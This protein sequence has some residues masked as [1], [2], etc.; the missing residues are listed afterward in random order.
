MENFK[1]ILSSND[2]SPNLKLTIKNTS[3]NCYKVLKNHLVLDGE[4]EQDNF[5]V[6]DN[7]TR[8]HLPYQG[9]TIKSIPDYINLDSGQEINSDIINL[10]LNYELEHNRNYEVFYKAMLTYASCDNSVQ[11]SG[12]Q[13]EFIE[14]NHIDLF[15]N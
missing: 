13:S 8:N 3:P 14:S 12:E 11:I 4:M 1:A 5:V 10:N 2:R 9:A 7:S 15:N 6:I